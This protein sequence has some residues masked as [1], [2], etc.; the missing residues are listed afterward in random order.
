MLPDAAFEP[1]G[2][3]GKP[4]SRAIEHQEMGSESIDKRRTRKYLLKP[5]KQTM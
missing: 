2:A 4:Q 5:E 3:Q 1:A